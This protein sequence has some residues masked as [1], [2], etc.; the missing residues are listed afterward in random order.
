MK[1]YFAIGFFAALAVLLVIGAVVDSRSFNT[2]QF[3]VSSGL[4]RLTNGLVVTNLRETATARIS[5]GV[6][7][8]GLAINPGG[9]LPG[10][11]RLVVE[12]LGPSEPLVIGTGGTGTKTRMDLYTL[13]DDPHI[14]FG[15]GTGSRFY[16]GLA[17]VAGV[18]KL[19]TLRDTGAL[20][21]GVGNTNP[22]SPLSVLGNATVSGLLSVNTFLMSN[23]AS[24]GKILTSD[25]SGNGTWSTNAGDTFVTN[26]FFVSGK[27]NTLVVTQSLTTLFMT[28]TVVSAD[29]NSR[30]TNT[31]L[32]GLTLT[33]GSPPTLS[34]DTSLNGLGIPHYK[35]RRTTMILAKGTGAGIDIWGD[36]A[37]ITGS[38]STANIGTNAVAV[39]IGTGAGALADG[40]LSGN[41][42]YRVERNVAFFWRGSLQSNVSERVFIGMSSVGLATMTAGD[43]P[44]ANYWGFQF[45]TLRL[46]ANWQLVTD[47]GTQTL[48]DSTMAF[49][50]NEFTLE[51][52]YDVSVA[53]SNIVFRI[54]GTTVATRSVTL[55]PPGGVNYAYIVGLETQ[56]ALDKRVLISGMEISA[57]K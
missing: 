30:L 52:I 53:V 39:S 7:T 29:S 54:N 24:A 16:F 31:A 14:I 42:N 33:A 41:G 48:T 2:G 50:T 3:D 28:N 36:T 23:G 46:D 8:N 6:I 47:N 55:M 49:S 26:M 13:N 56:D 35:F 34:V 37:T 57:D 10:A 44:A 18:T 15:D 17:S 9:A 22:A 21:V 11:N 40:G 51:A 43:D 1:R 25:A 5:N 20:G 12:S 27:G 4:V 32:S 45:S 19:L 38:G